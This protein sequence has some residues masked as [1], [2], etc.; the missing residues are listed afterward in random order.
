MLMC[1]IA[2]EQAPALLVLV[3]DLSPEM[4]SED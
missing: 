2:Q 1:A 3:L 4:W